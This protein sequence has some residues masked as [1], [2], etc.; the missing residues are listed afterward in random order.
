[1]TW[2]EVKPQLDPGAFTV[3]TVPKRLEKQKRDPWLDWVKV[4][5]GLPNL[6]AERISVAKTPAAHAK[7]HP[8][9]AR[10]VVA[11]KPKPLLKNR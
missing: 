3:R 10:I 5:Q 6:K 7:P 11:Q 9:G 4:D 2:S 1:M 8:G